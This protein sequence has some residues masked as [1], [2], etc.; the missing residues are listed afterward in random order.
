MFV[1][2]CIFALII[3]V[4][5][6]KRKGIFAFFAIVLIFNIL[7]LSQ[8]QAQG[9]GKGKTTIVGDTRVT[10]L[11]EKHIELNERVKTIPGYRIQVASLSGND[12][13]RRAFELKDKIKEAFPDVETYIVFD[14]P[15]FK[16]KVGD[17]RTKLEAF[18][19]LSDMKTSFPGTIIKDNVYALP[20]VLDELVPE[21]DEDQ[22]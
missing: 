9:N 19:F 22:F 8:S 3:T 2:I 16:V 5:I 10:Q 6:M 7:P 15:S 13:R 18:A 14:E 21:S 20:F 12:S 4:V 1:F 17:F 11:V